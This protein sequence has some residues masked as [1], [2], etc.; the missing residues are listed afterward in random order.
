[1]NIIDEGTVPNQRFPF[2]EAHNRLEPGGW[3]REVT[4]RELPV[5][6]EL[7]GVNMHLDEGAVRELHWHKQA[8][9][10]YMLCGRAR[11]TAFDVD[12]RTSADDVR[13]GDLWYFPA[14]IP[15]SIQGLRGGCEF[16]LVFD[17]GGFSENATFLISDWL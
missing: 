6:T 5:A 9:W 3:A 14:G 4:K 7:A 15:H 1:M 13:E 16:L 11:I 10:A 8:E 17:D 12:G 2:E